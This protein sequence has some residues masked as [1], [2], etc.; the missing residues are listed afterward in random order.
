MINSNIAPCTGGDLKFCDHQEAREQIFNDPDDS[1]YP[2]PLIYVCSPYGANPYNLTLTAEYAAF[3]TKRGGLPIV[4]HL[5]FKDFL[6][7]R[8]PRDRDA[9]TRMGI[10]LLDVCEEL[11]VFTRQASPG[12]AREIEEWE[13]RGR[14]PIYMYK[15]FESY[16]KRGQKNDKRG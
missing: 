3:V 8:D 1:L 16:K 9:G 11:W 4:P 5:Y 10:Q 2:R 7:D 12:M 14:R 13:Q 15:Q 6:D